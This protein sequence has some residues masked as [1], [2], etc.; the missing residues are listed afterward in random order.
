MCPKKILL[1]IASII[2]FGLN[3]SIEINDKF[4][5]YSQSIPNSGI[6]ID[7]TPVSGGVFNMGP[8]LN[9]VK[10]DSFWMARHEI[11]WEQYDLFAKEVMNDFMD[12][13]KTDAEPLGISADAI[14]LPTPPYVDMSFGMGRDGKPAISMTH[15]AAVMFT[16]W[17]SAKTGR[18]YR[19][20]TEA[21]WEYACRAGS[22]TNRYHDPDDLEKFEWYKENSNGSYQKTGTKEP[23][24][25]GLHD[26][27]GNVA[28]W[29]MD[30]YVENYI[31][32]LE[33]DPAENP[34]FKPT[35]LY[36]RAVRGGSWMDD[37]EEVHCGKRRGSSGKWKMLDPQL[38]KSL[39]W[40]TNAR[41]LGFRIIRPKT[42][43]SPEEI[44]QY[45]LE[46][47]EDF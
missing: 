23:N 39:W 42:T 21:E 31:E 22:E 14:S 12:Q 32:R 16:K 27:Q 10:V 18:F 8:G 45:W 46:A 41:F 24:E 9:Q 1:I 47:M 26:M 15:Y 13:I 36:P 5:P 29:T 28:E 37:Q 25:F 34:W 43:P 17:L 35:E 6:L 40:H 33:G 38:P 2:L 4:V 44:E 19:L 20:P 3:I 7:M 30:Q 11:T